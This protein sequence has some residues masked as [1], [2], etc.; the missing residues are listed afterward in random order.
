MDVISTCPLRV[1]S[2][3]WQPRTGAWALT[4]VCKAT[5]QLQPGVSPLAAAQEPPAEHD[6]HWEEDESRSLR[7]PADLVPFKDGA[8][9]LLV[10]HAFAAGAQPARVLPVRLAVGEVDK[11]VDVWCDRI[12]WQDG[13]LLEGQPFTRMPLRW[14]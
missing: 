7:A 13:R 5:F 11:R 14:E 8:D 3:I 4:V 12:F 6:V 2:V 10:G 9:V 1:A